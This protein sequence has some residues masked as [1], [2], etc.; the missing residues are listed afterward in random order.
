MTSGFA[1]SAATGW[2]LWLPGG[3]AAIL[4]AVVGGFGTWLAG[5]HAQ[6]SADRNA[7]TAASKLVVAELLWNLMVLAVPEKLGAGYLVKRRVRRS[8]SLDTSAW[9]AQAP[10]LAASASNDTFASVA[11][12][13]RQLQLAEAVPSGANIDAVVD[14]VKTALEGLAPLVGKDESPEEMARLVDESLAE[15]AASPS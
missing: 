11:A 7:A 15:A 1:F 2:D 13:Y 3:V 9:Q 12:A 8:V 10:R 4:G 6:K 14:A 5:R